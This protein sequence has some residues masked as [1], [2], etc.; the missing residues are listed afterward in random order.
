MQKI[1]LKIQKIYVKKFKKSVLKNFSVKN[2]PP[3]KAKNDFSDSI[4]ATFGIKLF[5]VS[6]NQNVTSKSEHFFFK[7]PL[8]DKNLV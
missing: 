4:F 1:V 2:N 8:I 3:F 5:G 7:K 6:H